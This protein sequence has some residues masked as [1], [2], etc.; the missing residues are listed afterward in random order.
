MR[1]VAHAH[2]LRRCA[3]A[4]PS[5]TYAAL[6]Q[7]AYVERRPDLARGGIFG[8]ECKRRAARHNA[9]PGNFRERADQL[10]GD[11]V[12]EILVLLVRA[13]VREGKDGDRC[14][15]VRSVADLGGRTAVSDAQRPRE[16]ARRSES[17]DTLLGQRAKHSLLECMRHVGASGGERRWRHGE[18]LADDRHR[19]RS[20]E[21]RPSCQHLVQCDAKAVNVAPA[22]DV[23]LAERLLGTHVHCGAQSEASLRELA[24]R[25]TR[26]RPAA[27][28]TKVGEDGVALSREEHVLRFD[29]AMDNPLA[30]RVGEG[31]GHAARELDRLFD[32][33]PT[34]AYEPGAQ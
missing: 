27:C 25:V 12:A 1:V 4:V 10:L 24:G 8:L 22:I 6:E 28:D 11:A 5:T 9:K 33:E 20:A 19:V 18:V 7:K 21:R 17:C 13:E 32:R 2:E 30:V 15:L 3:Q 34:F 26:R 23:R 14:A 16:V 29:V 31:V